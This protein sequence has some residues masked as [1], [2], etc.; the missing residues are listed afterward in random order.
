MIS[1]EKY[2]KNTLKKYQEFIKNNPFGCCDISL[3]AFIMYGEKADLEFALYNGAFITKQAVNGEPVFSFPYGKVDNR[4]IDALFDYVKQ[5]DLPFVL[6]GINDEALEKIKED[7][8][9]NGCI[10]NYDRR[11]SDYVYSFEEMKAF[12]GGKFSGQRNHINKFIKTYGEPNF[13]KIEKQ[14]IEEIKA[15]LYSYSQEHPSRL[16]REEEELRG[17]SILIDSFFDFNLLGGKLTLGDKIIG[18][19][20]GEII[21]DTLVIHVEKALTKYVGVYPT[22]FNSFVKYV[23]A[24]NKENLKFVNREDD[25]GDEGLR[26][27]KLQYKPVYLINKY[28]V[29]INPYWQAND[30]PVLKSDGVVLNKIEERDKANYFALCTDNELNK[31]WGYDFSEDDSITGQIDENTFFDM[32]A[33]DNSVGYSINLAIREKEDGELLGEIIIYNS[34]Y[35]GNVEIGCRVM[36]SAHGKGLGKRAFSLAVSYAERLGL[37]VTAKCFKQNEP[38]KKMILAC[39]LDLIKEDSNFYYFAKK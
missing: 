2:S 27:S 33:F 38:S 34:T 39:G 28:L 26:K 37:K 11:W 14:D 1:F 21:G 10:A 15:M 36:K 30:Y 29:K 12:A 6:Y 25:S 7:P 22:L 18:F 32:Q 5:N 19:T 3:G 16:Y 17:T 20:I 24:V 13:S 23:D 4:A 8:K 31:L 35:N 9:F